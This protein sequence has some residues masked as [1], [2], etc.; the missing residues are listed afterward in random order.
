MR[1]LA[2]LL[3]AMRKPVEASMFVYSTGLLMLSL[4]IMSP[5]YHAAESSA[6]AAFDGQRIGE[7][8]MA[9]VFIICSLPGVIVP[10]V[11]EE[12]RTH[13]L[14]HA[15]FG[16]F[17]AFFFLFLLRVILY[18][19]TPWLWIY[20]LMISLSSGIKRIFIEVRQE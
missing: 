19:W 16:I 1:R 2:W 4:Y 12:R 10:F 7:F 20:P 18:G 8:V 3:N 9:S 17:L 15:T 5:W 14:K 11:K 6:A 13:W